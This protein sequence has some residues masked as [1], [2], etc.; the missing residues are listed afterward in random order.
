MT[1]NIF[2]VLNLIKKMHLN[3]NLKLD[4]ENIKIVLNFHLLR[5]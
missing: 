4:F 2:N 3:S 1:K 5:S